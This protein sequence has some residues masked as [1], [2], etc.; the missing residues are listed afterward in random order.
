MLCLIEPRQPDSDPYRRRMAQVLALIERK[1]TRKVS[2]LPLF[3]RLIAAKGH[4]DVFNTCC[5]F[6]LSPRALLFLL[7]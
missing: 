4:M 2:R 5:C 3:E 6:G 1:E 7:I